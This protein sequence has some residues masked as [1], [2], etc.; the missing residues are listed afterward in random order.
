MH[1]N[2]L[3]QRTWTSIPNWSTWKERFESVTTVEEAVGLLDRGL[4]VHMDDPSEA[5]IYYLD[6]AD[7]HLLR[8]E[9]FRVET[10]SDELLSGLGR[11]RRFGQ[12]QARQ[13]LAGHAWDSLR[14]HYFTLREDGEGG[15]TGLMSV[16]GFGARVPIH[17]TEA[18]LALFERLV[19]FFVNGRRLHNYNSGYQDEVATKFITFFTDWFVRV[20]TRQI[21]DSL[22]G[23][24]RELALRAHALLPEALVLLEQL[25]MIEKVV[26]MELAEPERVLELLKEMALDHWG[27]GKE[28]FASLEAAFAHG[29]ETARAYFLLELQVRTKHLKK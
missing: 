20:A 5:I 4:R 13:I 8:L 26:S 17:Y 3:L 16:Q 28:R 9:S 19:S 1:T 24:Q 11:L 7:G 21:P 10:D 12:A 22:S 27:T 18:G 14:K 6:L 25:S 23:A 2:P 29:N 15:Y